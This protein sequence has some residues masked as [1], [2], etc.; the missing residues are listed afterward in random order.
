[1]ILFLPKVR[2][3]FARCKFIRYICNVLHLV[4]VRKLA[5]LCGR[6]LCLLICS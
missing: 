1:M 4:G 3:M 6:F 5:K 2:E